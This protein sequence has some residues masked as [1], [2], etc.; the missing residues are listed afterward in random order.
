[1][2]F[3]AYNKV[4]VDKTEKKTGSIPKDKIQRTSGCSRRKHNSNVL[5]EKTGVDAWTKVSS[6]WAK[7]RTKDQAYTN[8]CPMLDIT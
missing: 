4:K 8:I 5:T 3:V 1:V 6:T 7:P 2:V